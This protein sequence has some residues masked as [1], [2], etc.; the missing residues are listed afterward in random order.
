MPDDPLALPFSIV[1]ELLKKNNQSERGSF[2]EGQMKPFKAPFASP[3]VVSGFALKLAERCQT[4]KSLPL[5]PSPRGAE[6]QQKEEQRPKLNICCMKWQLCGPR[7]SL[8][9]FQPQ[10]PCTT[11]LS[12]EPLA[13]RGGPCPLFLLPVPQLQSWSRVNSSPGTCPALLN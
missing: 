3:T 9:S 8:C 5:A 12:Y 1:K 4:C 7:S 11:R 2:R 10:P 13:G 6:L